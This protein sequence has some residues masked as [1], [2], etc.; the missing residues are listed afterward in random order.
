MTYVKEIWLD[1][2]PTPEV[3]EHPDIFQFLFG[4]VVGR[5]SSWCECKTDKCRYR[6]IVRVE[7]VKEEETSDVQNT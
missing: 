5:A 1:K 6:V 2:V 4:L 3:E 7:S